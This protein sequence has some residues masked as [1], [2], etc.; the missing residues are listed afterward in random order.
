M[1]GNGKTRTAGRARA[2]VGF[3]VERLESAPPAET[4]PNAIA[5]R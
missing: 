2:V 1:V 3:F 5:I 4:A